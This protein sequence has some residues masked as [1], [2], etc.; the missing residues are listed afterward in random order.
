MSDHDDLDLTARLEDELG[1]TLQWCAADAPE[2]V[3]TDFDPATDR[4]D[5]PDE[6]RVA[7]TDPEWLAVLAELDGDP[8][9]HRRRGDLPVG[10][11]VVVREADEA[12]L[13]AWPTEDAVSDVV[14]TLPVAAVTAAPTRRDAYVEA[15]VTLVAAVGEALGEDA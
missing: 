8:E 12:T 10:L 3:Q 2:G 7:T 13:M 15:V 6:G 9:F 1:L 14:L 5:D 11:H 4:G